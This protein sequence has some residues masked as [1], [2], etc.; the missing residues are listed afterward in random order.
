ME[1]AV[2]PAAQAEATPT[3]GMAWIWIGAILM[4]VGGMVSLTDRR[5]RVGA[6]KP[7]RSRSK[8]PASGTAEA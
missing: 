2:A 8:K 6:P 5:Y 1:P 3:G 4:A 7:A